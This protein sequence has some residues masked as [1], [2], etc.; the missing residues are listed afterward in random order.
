ME[1]PYGKAP[2]VILLVALLTGGALLG[3]DVSA[4]TSP[5]KPNL[6][7]ATFDK[8]QAAAYA[9]AMPS[10]ERANNCKVQ[11]QLVDQ[12]AIIYRLQSAMQVG[13]DVPDLAEVIYYGM[14]TFVRGPIESMGFADLTDRVHG[15]GMWDRIV[16]SRFQMWSSRG[17]IF[18][19]PHDVHP[20]ML[21]YRKD[22]IEQL[23][24][25]VSKL[26]T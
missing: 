20:V 1:F 9:A 3:F 13:A 26:T 25:D 6:V 23:N 4:E 7:L 2:L 19:L 5:G 22:L 8:D 14:G 21:V 24:I 16:Q 17:R 10:F 15:S 12:R 11:V 18:A